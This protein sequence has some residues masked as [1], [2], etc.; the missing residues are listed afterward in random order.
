[1]PSDSPCERARADYVYVRRRL[2]TDLDSGVTLDLARNTH[3]TQFSDVPR[4]A[5]IPVKEAFLEVLGS[6]VSGAL[7]ESG[8]KV[9]RYVRGL[10]G[11]QESTV[12]YYGDRTNMCNAALANGAFAKRAY[13][14]AI[15]PAVLAVAEKTFADG[16]EI[17]AATV[18]GLET[19]LRL[20][21]AASP[22]VPSERPLDPISTFGPFGAMVA[23]GK[24]L[25]LSVFDM[26]NAL[27]C[28]A[29]Q[30]AGT[31]Q[32]TETGSESR[33]LV[34]GFAASYG[35]KAASMARHGVSGARD[36]LEGKAGFFMCIAG[37]TMERKPKY[38]VK[39]VNGSFG[40]E[41]HV[42]DA[43]TAG[44]EG[45]EVK[46]RR[47]L[48]SAGFSEA[49]QQRVIDIVNNLEEENDIGPL[50]SLLVKR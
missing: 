8:L 6:M 37:V 3:A 17:L 30:A 5:L 40:T 24:L 1:M 44:G 34:P 15:V 41:W 12:L 35:V 25:R 19:M 31:L 45:R 23:A 29:A 4:D 13:E 22:T 36:T 28:C 7:D 50:V 46:V 11:N 26:E 10:G 48:A 38:D 14:S 39:K 42:R 47:Q 18:T 20:S 9:L 27:T 43:I 49:R 32:S 16:R 21:K 2:P 33:C